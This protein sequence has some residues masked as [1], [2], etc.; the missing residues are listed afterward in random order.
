MSFEKLLLTFILGII[1]VQ[2]HAI[3]NPAPSGVFENSA[4]IECHEKD[5]RQL[6]NDW[7]NSSHASTLPVTDCVACHGKLHQHTAETTSH[8]RVIV[9]GTRDL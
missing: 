2:V 1:S 8:P 3:D 9:S 4:C 6:I 7:R 5:N